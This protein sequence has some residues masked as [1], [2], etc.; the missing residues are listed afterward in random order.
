MEETTIVD[1][2][3]FL[4]EHRFSGYQWLIF[5]M[6]FVIVL[7]DGFDTAAIGFIAPS[8]LSEWHLTKAGLGPVLSAAL[9]GLACGAI[10]SGPVADKWGRR[11]VVTASVFV[12]GAASVG[13]GFAT[14][15]NE[16]TT[17]R[18][19]TGIGLG[20]AMPNAITVMSEF[21]PHRRRALIVNMTFCGFALGA[22]LG[23]FLAAW[24]IPLFGW[25][26]VLLFGG[27]VPL[28]LSVILLLALPESI[29]YM[30]TKRHPVEKIRAVL[31]R[32][33]SAAQ[34]ATGFKLE[35]SAGQDRNRNGIQVVL[36]R[37]HILGSVMLW[38]CYFMGLVIFYGLANWMP[39]LFKDAGIGPQRAALISALF[40]LGGVGT[41]LCG[42][43]M[44]RFNADRVIAACFGFGA[45]SVYAIGQAVGTTGLLMCAV[46]VAG[47]L[48]NTGLSSM[49]ALAAA[50]YPTAGRGTGVAW[51]LGVGRFGGIA[52]SFLVAELARQQF[53]LP[54]IFTVV[55]VAGFIASAALIIK[56]AGRKPT[57]NSDDTSKV[58]SL[59]H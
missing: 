37:S 19:I 12:F 55:A 18:F 21:C 38:V 41:I 13:C 33:N 11:L 4:N 42:F 14:S 5:A 46:F 23:G 27:G 10:I 58:E 3:T 15:L 28:I 39:I 40:P 2:Q 20:A 52:G 26:G 16:L 30:V 57:L 43:L 1:V 50:F 8:L 36:S 6:C 29:R 56:Q 24:M 44:D 53:S 22:A 47:L 48:V 7:M 31:T 9:L 59:A 45:I 54:G 34:F 51:M 35:E 49:P 32:I 17:L 25:R